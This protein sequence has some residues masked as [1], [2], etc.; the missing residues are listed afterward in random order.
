MR[1]FDSFRD[2]LRRIQA[3][4]GRFNGFD[5]H[6]ELS[7]LAAILNYFCNYFS[8]DE[9]IG[10]LNLLFDILHDF[11]AVTQDEILSFT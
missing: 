7:I 10:L 2:F 5:S 9:F 8:T 11:L 3:K 4:T 6:L 1:H